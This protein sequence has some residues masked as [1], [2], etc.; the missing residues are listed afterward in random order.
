MLLLV[1][2]SVIVSSINVLLLCFRWLLCFNMCVIHSLL[3]TLLNVFQFMKKVLYKYG[4]NNNN[5]KKKK[6]KKKIIIIIIIM[7]IMIIFKNYFT[8]CFRWVRVYKCSQHKHRWFWWRVCSPWWLAQHRQRI[9]TWTQLWILCI[10]FANDLEAWL[11]LLNRTLTLN[12]LLHLVFKLVM[13]H[14]TWLLY[15]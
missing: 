12:R 11:Y 3:W 7:I 15:G 9:W 1:P 13:S 2:M 14:S 6:K 10:H 4:Y 5:N 8:L